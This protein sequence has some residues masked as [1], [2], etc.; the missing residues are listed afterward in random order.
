MDIA[1]SIVTSFAGLSLLLVL[2]KFLRVKI[3]LLQKLYIPTSV[4]AGILGLIVIQVSGSSIPAGWT[5]GWTM[6][7]G[8]LINI[9]FAALFLGVT[10]PSF[11][12]I[13]KK[14]APQ[15][16]YGQVVAW[17]QYFIG[18]LVVL[19]F[20]KPLFKVPDVF[21]VIVE[22]GFE[23]GHGTAAGLKET[24]ETYNWSAGTHY[25]LA[26]A[27]MGV[28]TAIVVGII[29]INW[30]AR[31]G[32]TQRL[33]PLNKLAK[34]EWGGFYAKDQRPVAGR[35]TVSADSIDS[36][37]LHL[38]IVGIAVLI[39][40]GLKQ[41]LLIFESLFPYLAEKKILQG[42]PLFPLCM[43]GGL[44]VQIVV[45]RFKRIFPIDH[46]LMQRLSGTALDF[47]VVAAISTISIDVIAEG[48]V[49][50]LIIVACGVIW[51]VFCVV[52]LARRVLPNFW[53]ERAIAEMGQ[54]MGVTA[55]GL[56]L[57]RAVDPESETDAPS[58][59]GYKQLLHEPI[60]GGGFWTSIAV[61]LV[62]LKGGWLVFII[63]SCVIVFW[64][65]VLAILKKRSG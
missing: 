37:A 32:Y 4:I 36:L 11:S 59:F 24:F 21:G 12:T 51:N 35:Q 56:L 8:F 60:M 7:P 26:S 44:I 50:F 46:A 47:L 53:F 6:L 23:G 25:A 58:A 19:L 62:I 38:A 22:V 28:V 43:L 29:L 16:G 14:S 49:P 17:G 27:T 54:S 57:L 33:K 64:L 34:G 5:A 3:K 9:V 15:L 52:F 65:I 1:T 30:A 40:F 20:L 45:S 48:L 63:S 13:W 10:I 31:K 55:T 61:P 2:G 39:G 42:F 18:L 41:G